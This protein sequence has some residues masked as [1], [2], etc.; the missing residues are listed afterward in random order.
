MARVHGKNADYSFNGV[1]LEG[2]MK[3]ITMDFEV[4]EA[5]ITSFADAWQ[6]FLA[7]KPTVKAEI[8]GVYDQATTAAK[9]TLLAAIGAGPKTSVF[10]ITG[11]GP[12]AGNP[13]YTCTASG[14]TGSLVESLRI[15][16]PVGDAGSWQ[17]TIRNSGNTLRAVA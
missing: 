9:A 6:N 5:E 7:G 16:L 17:A 1:A 14:L 2:G 10:D 13:E 4:P 3:E 12:A 11:S 15:S 8:S